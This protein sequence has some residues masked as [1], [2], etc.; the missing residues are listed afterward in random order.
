[1]TPGIRCITASGTTDLTSTAGPIDRH[2]F[3][4]KLP[5]TAFGQ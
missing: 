2:R 1:M 5:S 3:S 4:V